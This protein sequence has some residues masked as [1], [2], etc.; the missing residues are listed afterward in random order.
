MDEEIPLQTN[1]ISKVF[2]NQ[3]NLKVYEKSVPLKV[4]KSIQPTLM[5]NPI[6]SAISNTVINLIGGETST[7]AA[8]F[9]YYI[10]GA[11]IE[12]SSSQ[13]DYDYTQ[14]YF[15]VFLEDGSEVKICPIINTGANAAS[16]AIPASMLALSF[17]C[18]LK[19]QQGST[20]TLHSAAPSC[21]GSLV[22][23]KLDPTIY[24]LGNGK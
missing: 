14:S 18:P 2:Y 13:G 5:L 22:L 24:N 6:P 8:N 21:I 4:R 19:L 7:L 3:T 16:P 9:D 20:I 15:D 12:A 10:T 17:P 1:N 23:L 11:T